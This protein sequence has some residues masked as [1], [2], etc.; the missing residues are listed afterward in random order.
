MY[1]V[2]KELD[3]RT[4]KGIAMASKWLTGGVIGML[5]PC[6]G[7]LLVGCGKSS[8]DPR[9]PISGKVTWQGKPLAGAEVYVFNDASGSS[10]VTD[11]EGRYR[12]TGG[13]PPGAARV[14]ITL[15]PA[16]SV[17]SADAPEEIQDDPEQ[18]RAAAPPT[19]RTRNQKNATQQTLPP[20][21]SDPIR[22]QLT[23][24]IP[25]SGTNTA[26]FDL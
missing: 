17:S 1:E 9:V 15:E 12:L 8:V 11:A 10:G 22:S 14:Y 13:L 6:L 18:L 3:F 23:I 24:D 16:D 2:E 5:V 19:G 20:E 26:N 21:V 4:S 7:L 25:E